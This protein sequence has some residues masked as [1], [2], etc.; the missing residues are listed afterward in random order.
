MPPADSRHQ[1]SFEFSAVIKQRRT[2]GAQR[3]D[4][5]IAFQC[6]FVFQG[7]VAFFAER[8]FL[9]RLEEGASTVLRD[10][11]KGQTAHAN[12]MPSSF[13][14]RVYNVSVLVEAPGSEVSSLLDR[15]ILPSLPRRDPAPVMPDI[16]VRVVQADEQLQLSIQDSLVKVAS[17]ANDLIVPLIKVLDDE[18]I[19]RL[20]T[21][22]AIHSGAVVCEDRAILLPGS[23]HSGKSSLVAELVR[24]GATYFSDEF[25]L[26]DPDGCVHPYPRPL[27]LRNGR[28]R[29][30]PV[31][32]E[33][34]K[35]TVGCAAVPVGWIFALRYEPDCGWEVAP[36]PQSEAVL[37]LLKN[38]PHFLAESPEV[39]GSF[40]KAASGAKCYT[41]CRP[42][43]LPAVDEIMRLIHHST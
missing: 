1:P 18:I 25:A 2:E 4:T 32:P 37:T 20:D 23:T 36:I 31:L 19:A 7:A 16:C 29:Q 5:G 27:L 33:N 42:D 35:A 11:V 28:P 10:K 38:T 43:V 12:S 24:R 40:Q 39:L 13:T 26:I 22:R 15:H 41:G 8:S 9:T 30:I 21:L 14:V 3:S 34:L 6:P 17:T